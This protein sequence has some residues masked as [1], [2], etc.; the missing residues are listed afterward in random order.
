MSQ[1]RLLLSRRFGPLLL[2]TFLTGL[3]DHMFRQGLVTCVIVTAWGLSTGGA[4][5]LAALTT[6]VIMLPF[7]LLSGLAG[8]VLDRGVKARA[9]LLIKL[10]EL[11]IV[12]VGVAGVVF[13]SA[14]LMWLGLVLLGVRATF[15][16]AA[17]YSVLPELSEHDGELV[18]ANALMV[19]VSFG[20][21]L[22]GTLL[23]GLLA[24]LGGEV[25]KQFLSLLLLC[26]SVCGIVPAIFIPHRAAVAPGLKVSLNPLSSTLTIMRG[27][28]RERPLL[29]S[30]L[31]LS[32]FWML[33]VAVLATIPVYGGDAT[34]Q[35]LLM[36]VLALGM[37]VG[38][39]VAAKL[40]HGELELGLVPVGSLGMCVFLLDLMLGGL[41]GIPQWDGGV[42][43]GL[44][45]FAGARLAC[46]LFLL[47]VFGSFFT[48]PLYVL[49]QQDARPEA[50]AQTIGALNVMS[51]LFTLCGA[52]FVTTMVSI[53]EADAPAIFGTLA[54]MHVL[55]S[56]FI[57]HQV[58]RF[59]WRFMVWVLT[60]VIYRLDIR[61]TEYIPR[62]GA[63]VLSCSHPS[64]ID[65]MF[66]AAASR[67]PPRFIMH[68][69]FFKSRLVGWLF[70]DLD[71]IPIAPR[72]EDESLMH[73]AFEL[74]AEALAEGELVCIFPEGVVTFDGELNVF[75]PGIEK[76]VQRTP[77]P[78]VPIVIT[79][80]WG[81]T[82][83][84]YHGKPMSKLSWRWRAPVAVIVG[85][86][87]PAEGFTAQH[88]GE[89][90]AALGGFKAPPTADASTKS[91]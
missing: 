33:G 8:E 61:H 67:R 13:E 75:R 71:I 73:Q 11:P 85:E 63:A 27:V 10:M 29:L 54:L 70:R 51:A 49:L 72:S 19:W 32:W 44:G 74:V 65:F 5:E 20:A 60:R 12:M 83:S 64:Y 86:P 91:M 58:P 26:V 35:A 7:T 62:E 1:L 31:G 42:G 48:V 55:V 68:H 80:M 56:W 81:S 57:Y 78:V 9:I 82:F 15:F 39:S 59:P 18:E 37:G 69:T 40:S 46:D 45:T 4:S 16:G 22:L 36:G 90:T 3:C 89:V 41:M 84:R 30:A 87:L 53:E 50:R 43:A 28:I 2:T 76:I 38:A 47:G 25:G 14:A 52:W 88:L 77:V 6:I 79:G 17:K 24:G 21:I 34:A 23:G 66:V